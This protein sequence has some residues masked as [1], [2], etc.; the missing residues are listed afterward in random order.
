MVVL[1]VS[2]NGPGIPPGDKSRIFEPYFTTKDAGT[3]LGLAIVTSIVADHQGYIRCYD[4]H[5]RGTK[6]I[7]ELPVSPRAAT[8]R[9][10][11]GETTSGTLKR[12]SSQ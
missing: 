5:P 1:E 10:F 12:T 2:D 9:R 7:I 6:F 3:G 4:N 11:S 8:Q